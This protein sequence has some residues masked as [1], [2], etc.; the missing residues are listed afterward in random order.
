MSA[1]TNLNRPAKLAYTIPE[2][3]AACGVGTTFVY[4]EIQAGRLKAL[5][6]GRRTIIDAQEAKRWLASL[7]SAGHE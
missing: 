5:K 4:G 2:F 3:G 6:A 1:A 7:R